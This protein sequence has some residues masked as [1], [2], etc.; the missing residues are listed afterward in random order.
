MFLIVDPT[1]N[2]TTSTI[3]E[4][5]TNTEETTSNAVA[6]NTTE[7]SN[8]TS[9][10]ELK[11]Y[12]CTLGSSALEIVCFKGFNQNHGNNG[13]NHQQAEQLCNKGKT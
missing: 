3:N 11:N 4:E 5:A 12:I 2:S 8:I 1:T 10:T 13:T 6:S 9:V 7:A